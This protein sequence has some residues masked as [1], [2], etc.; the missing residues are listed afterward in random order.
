[1][2]LTGDTM[3][4]FR[5]QPGPVPA[6]EF[7]AQFAERE[8]VPANAW[9]ALASRL[10]HQRGEL[11]AL[12]NVGSRL[13]DAALTLLMHRLRAAGHPECLELAEQI[14]VQRGLSGL[15]GWVEETLRDDLGA[16]WLVDVLGDLHEEDSSR[17]LISLLDH[18]QDS[19]R[20]RASD[21]LASHRGRIDGRRLIRYL[22]EP[23]VRGL[24][25]P[26]PFA[27]IHALH[28][29]ANPALEPDF[30]KDAARRAERVLINCVRHEKRWQLRG[31]AIAALGEIGSRAGVRCLV[32]MLHREESALHREVVI[33]LRKIHPDRA[34]I[35]LIS[36]LQSPDPII[37]EEA[38]NALGEIGDPAAVKRLRVL[39]E[40]EN[41]DVRQE[42]VLALGKL[43]GKEVLAALERALSDQNPAVRAMACFA[44]A[45]T[46]GTAAQGKLISALYDGSADV[47]GEAA[48]LLGNVGDENALSHLESA[49][50]DSE[51]D[52]FGER[53]ASIARRALYRLERNRK[54]ATGS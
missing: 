31:D 11:E 45:E 2:L 54:R 44:L 32:D 3:I 15:H 41:P 19:I 48:F 38:A 43:G 42:A 47:R 36:L 34:L 12:T 18:P 14:L 23:L 24:D 53:I 25:E 6:E 46:V 33:A 9:A 4:D 26:N 37:R 28:R 51:R 20:R 5:F 29:L 13:D 16:R 21:G 50:L 52:A 10:R 8:P 17:L 1:M 40:D 39:I 35:A 30:G 49:L 22:A 27:A 7:L